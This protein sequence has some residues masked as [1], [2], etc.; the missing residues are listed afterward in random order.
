MKVEP[1]STQT[2]VMIVFFPDPEL[3]V[4]VTVIS[5]PEALVYRT[6]H[7]VPVAITFSPVNA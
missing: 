4:P 6:L 1:R 2:L 5:V 3:A 7:E